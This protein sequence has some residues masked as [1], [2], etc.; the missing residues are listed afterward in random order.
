MSKLV[1]CALFVILG[2]CPV[3]EGAGKND[4]NEKKV[5]RD[6]EPVLWRLPQSIASMDLSYGP[7][8]REHEPKGPFVFVEEDTGGSSPEV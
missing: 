3:L 1:A 4:A 8:G 6:S 2:N 7:G 5:R